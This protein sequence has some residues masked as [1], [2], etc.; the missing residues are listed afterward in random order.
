[1]AEIINRTKAALDRTPHILLD[2][3]AAAVL[4][5]NDAAARL[6]LGRYYYLPESKQPRKNQKGCVALHSV[7][8]RLMY[9]ASKWRKSE[10]DEYWKLDDKKRYDHVQGISRD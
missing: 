3:E 8:P 5:L 10:I 7:V 9:T 6:G 2:K 1:M 4:A